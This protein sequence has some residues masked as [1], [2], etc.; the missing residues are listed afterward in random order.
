MG[1]LVMNVRSYVHFLVVL[2]DVNLTYQEKYV[3]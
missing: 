2:D 1:D 3:I